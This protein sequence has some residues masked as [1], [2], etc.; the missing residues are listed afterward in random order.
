MKALFAMFKKSRTT[1]QIV[2]GIQQQVNELDARI[3]ED[4]R[5]VEAQIKKEEEELQKHEE[6]V[7]AEKA[8]HDSVIKT[9][10]ETVEAANE[11]SAWAKRI[12][13][14]MSDFIA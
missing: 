10:D 12:K 5:I 11:S 9:I 2:A 6:K 8:R 13:Q 4:E 1:A 3:Q 7:K 14:R